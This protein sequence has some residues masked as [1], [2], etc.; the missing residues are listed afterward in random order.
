MPVKC[1]G[2]SA[3]MGS[4]LYMRT[5]S[6]FQLMASFSSRISS[7]F[8]FFFYRVSSSLPK[9]AIL[10]LTPL[11]LLFLQVLTKASPVDSIIWIP[12]GFPSIVSF[13]LLHILSCVCWLLL[14]AVGHCSLRLWVMYALRDTSLFLYA[15][16]YS[17][18]IHSHIFLTA[19]IWK[20]SKCSSVDEWT[21]CSYPMILLLLFS[22]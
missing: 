1:S 10:S 11:I 22:H 3:H 6:Q 12:A 2:Q 15:N 21:N 9:I 7:C 8:L 20:H 19:Q 16:V 18:I 13:S 17:N 4:I 14:L 5:L